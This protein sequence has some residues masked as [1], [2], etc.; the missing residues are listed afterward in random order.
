[1]TKSRRLAL[2]FGL[3]ALM[4]AVAVPAAVVTG[5]KGSPLKREARNAAEPDAP[6]I[7]RLPNGRESNNLRTFAEEDYQNRA[8]PSA[9][10]NFAQVQAAHSAAM[11]IDAKAQ[12]PNA[13]LKSWQAIGPNGMNI[14]TLG[15]QTYGPPTNWSGRITAIGVNPSCTKYN[16]RLYVATAGGGVWRANDGLALHPNWKQISDGQIPTNSIGTLLVDPTVPSGATIYAGTGE[17]NG[18]SD[19]EAGMGV[20]RS[21]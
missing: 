5:S 15:T 14:D 20:Y 21:T 9:N 17:P 19:S 18:S 13:N 12:A 6:A 3:L 4:A 11:R 10:V 2:L 1:M 8:Y 7:G 16:C